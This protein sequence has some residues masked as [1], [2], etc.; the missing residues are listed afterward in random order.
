MVRYAAISTFHVQQKWQSLPLDQCIL[1]IGIAMKHSIMTV[2]NKTDNTD[3]TEQSHPAQSNIYKTPD[4]VVLTRSLIDAYDK[5]APLF[6]KYLE[7][8]GSSKG[9]EELINQDLDPLNIRESYLNFLD[10][11]ANDPG[12]FIDLQSQFMHEWA[13]LWQDSIA[14][15]M[16]AKNERKTVIEPE[17]GDRRFRAPEWQESALF[18]FIK[19]SYLLTCRWMDKTVN[20]VDGIDEKH[21]QKLAFAAKLFSNAISPTNFVLTNPE[22][23]SETLKTG[24]ENLV[25]GLENLIKD[26]ERGN[27]DLKIKTTDYNSF[28]LGEN[29][30]TS[31]GGVI[32]QNDLMQLIQY[33][34]TTEKAF[35]TPLLIVPP[36]INKYYILDLK[37][38]NSFI[39]WAVEQGHSV[40][41]ISWVNPGPELAMKRFEDYMKEG[42]IEALEQIEK[43]TGENKANV[44]GYCLGGT[45]LTITMA[46][47][48]KKQ[49]ADKIASA[50]F[51][52]TLIDFEK[53]GELKLFLDKEQIDQI[54]KKIFEKGILEGKEMQQTFSLLR[55]ND[56]I[57]SFVVN[58]Y[59]MGREPFPFDLL[60]WNDDCTN[61]PAAM[62]SF[63]LRK[64]YLENALVKSGGITIDNI[65]ID[66][67]KIK[68]P[69]FFLST[70]EDHIA[71]WKATYSGI[72]K[73]SGPVEFTLAASGHIA[74]VINPPSK[75]KYCYWSNDKTPDDPDEWLKSAKQHSGSWWPHWQKWITR[76]AGKK[77]LA[78]KVKKSIE[79]APGSYVMMKSGG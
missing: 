71:P 64:M 4:M 72:K 78:R 48:A 16:G 35:K 11:I 74:G 79:P 49:Q 60:Y 47:L 41:T 25:R 75:N 26:M 55:A 57:W 14:N 51:L 27:G 70:R 56:L 33:E 24:G 31:K 50:T 2:N 17:A 8:Y 59:L 76:Y 36:W 39:A 44:I 45:L 10:S 52:T 7:K 62:H 21:R 23:I 32:Y 22:V 20:H 63:Y 29:I 12:K 9:F 67:R 19:Q 34:P 65:P 18:D 42:I 66:T 37:S 15:F 77:V 40:F 28:K 3:K 54:E 13:T 6:E 73:L 68:T 53:A 58:N 46:Y 38:E 5:A 1:I 30:A 69:A 43:A 61:M